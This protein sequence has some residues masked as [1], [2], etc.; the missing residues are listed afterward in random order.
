MNV[1]TL[2]YVS[3]F[4]QKTIN[5]KKKERRYTLIISLTVAQ[6]NRPTLCTCLLLSESAPRALSSLHPTLDRNDSFSRQ[7][8][9]FINY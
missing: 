7:Q 9:N 1:T 8:E 5:R 6:Q 2:G 4:E 3:T